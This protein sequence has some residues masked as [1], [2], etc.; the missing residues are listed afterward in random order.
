MK[1]KMTHR[2]MI[3]VVCRRHLDLAVAAGQSFFSF[4]PYSEVCPEEMSPG[5]E[6]HALL[7]CSLSDTLTMS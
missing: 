3:S 6:V 7:L 1:Q 2:N 4:Q 5:G